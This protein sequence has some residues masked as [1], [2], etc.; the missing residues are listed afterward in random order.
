MVEEIEPTIAAFIL[1][2]AFDRSIE[3]DVR[4]L[5]FAITEPSITDQDSCGILVKTAPSESVF[6]SLSKI[7]W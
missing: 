5:V 7:L 2:R 6:K 1:F 4:S 3:N